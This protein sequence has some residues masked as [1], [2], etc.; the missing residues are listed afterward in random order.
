[1]KLSPMMYSRSKK[2]IDNGCKSVVDVRDVAEV[3][4][5]L[6]WIT[7][8]CSCNITVNEI[9]TRAVACIQTGV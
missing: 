8:L 1:M 4:T 5:P 7:R 6:T 2:E 9:R 3:N